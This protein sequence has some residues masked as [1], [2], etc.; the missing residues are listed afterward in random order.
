MKKL[1]LM[2]SAK[3]KIRLDS[4]SDMSK[5]LSPLVTLFKIALIIALLTHHAIYSRLML[6]MKMMEPEMDFADFSTPVL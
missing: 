3:T 1:I 4:L 2:L 5:D 6:S